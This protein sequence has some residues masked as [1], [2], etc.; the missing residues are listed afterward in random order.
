MKRLF[1]CLLPGLLL[2][3][4][5]HAAAPFLDGTY[6]SQ[7]FAGVRHYRIFLPHG[8][9]ASAQR[10]PVIYYFH[11][12]SDRYTLEKYDDGKDTVPKIAAFT[13]QHD[14]IVVA[15]DGYVA[16]D[17]EG[18]YGG[19]PYDVRRDGGDYDF[20][21][22]FLELIRFIDGKYR[23]LA[24]RRFRA[25]SGLSMGGF[26]SLYLSARYPDVV[27][28][29]SAFNPAPELYAGEKGRRSLWRP[30]DHVLNHEATRIRLVRASGDYISQYHEETR[31]AYAISH[32]VPFEFR[33]DEYH[34]H[35][36]TSI[37]ETFEFHMR[38]FADAALDT[39]PAEWNYDS[40]YTQFHVWGAD[41]S[42]EIATPAVISLE[43]VTK[44]GLRVRTRQWSPDGPPAS[45]AGIQIRTAPVY[46]PGARYGVSVLSL[47]TGQ[48]RQTTAT[49]GRDG[50]VAL[51][52]DCG[53]EEISFHGPGIEAQAPVLLPPTAKGAWRVLPARVL[54][55]PVRIFNP[56]STPLTGVRATLSSQYPTVEILRGE[57]LIE[58]IAP[59]GVADPGS[60]FQVRFTAGEGDFAHAR[61][62]LAISYDGGKVRS[63]D[64]DVLVAP[65]PVPAPIAVE[66]LD[67]R[68]RTFPVF[69]QKGNNGGGGSIAR[70]V[71]EGQGNGNGILEPGERATFWVKTAQ[72]LDPFDKNNW[73]R[74]KVYSD[75][76]W[77][78]E[79]ADIQEDKQRE[80]TGAQ[81]RTS[82]IELKP[83]TPAGTEIPV[84]LD[85]ESW[86]FRYTPDVRY[87]Q[88]PLYQAFQLHKHY[89]FTWKWKVA[90]P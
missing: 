44:G 50:R 25:T 57:A 22:Y 75:S 6:H 40:A 8:Y 72:G 47:A 59:S 43:H 55:L 42:T 56:R 13:A 35:W 2:A 82:L 77:I 90:Q 78:E 84:I 12:H 27:G 70:T 37:G 16:R 88:E 28:S 18:F 4:A 71:T 89:L 23:T 87:G 63:R 66:V 45:C 3:G 85:C 69:R 53:G 39:V 1:R 83:G 19:S 48:A 79:V 51:D 14:V 38:A 52:A 9:E 65:D 80:W 60:E 61:L 31:A 15:P 34:R 7:V 49:A 29:A 20:G 24:S 21:E 74:A 17:Y 32:S 73:R 81:N 33:Q 10:Y 64:I 58:T 30:K 86:S 11:G 5:G 76:P 54:S 46:Q 26:M 67:G 41:V 62:Q 68:T 36:A